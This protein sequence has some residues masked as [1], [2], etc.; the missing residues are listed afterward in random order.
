MVFSGRMGSQ[1]CYKVPVATR[2]ISTWIPARCVTHY[3]VV[4]GDRFLGSVTAALSVARNLITKPLGDFSFHPS[5]RLAGTVPHLES[6]SVIGREKRHV[7]QSF[8]RT[9]ASN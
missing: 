4:V 1:G 2:G 3:F 6:L 8:C 7:K 5:H 9:A